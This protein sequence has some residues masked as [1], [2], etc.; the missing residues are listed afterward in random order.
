[1]LSFNVT[2][3]GDAIQIICDTRGMGVL[4]T[5]LAYLLE[6]RGG[7]VHLYAD[8]LSDTSP[9]GEKAFTE[10][11]IDFMEGDPVEEED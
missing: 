1:M 9:Y 10:V 5:K 3:N 7:H 4:M 8:Q 11:V 2:E 6:Q